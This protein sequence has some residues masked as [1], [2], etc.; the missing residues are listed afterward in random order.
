M[1]T[2][3]AKPS[4]TI[5]LKNLQAAYNGESNA[6]ARYAAF[7]QKA[8]E[9][10]FHRAA[11]LF[12][13]ASRAEQIHAANH[14]AV[15]KQMGGTPQTHIETPVVR[16]TAENLNVAIAGEEYERDLMYPDFIREAEGQNNTAAVRTFSY[17]LEAE[18]E[19]ARLYTEALTHLDQ[20][21]SK[22]A[23]YVCANCGY[24]VEKLAFER[25]PVCHHPKEKFE[26]I[27]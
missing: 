8:D 18:T 27:S 12:R 14:A 1:T 4:T 2:V 3:A 6:C 19:H 10:G 5:T 23:Y 9:E 24:T 20:M 25:C 13:A 7:A 17:A 26:E 21:K 22:T 16:S 15:I 11:S